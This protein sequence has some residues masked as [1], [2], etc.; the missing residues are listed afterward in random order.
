MAF[1]KLV[2]SAQLDSDLTSVANAIRA[3]SGTSGQLAFPAGFVSE[4]NAISGGGG[5]TGKYTGTFTLVNDGFMPEITHNL[6]TDKIAVMIFPQANSTVTPHAGYIAWSVFFIALEVL[7]NGRSIT[8]DY[9]AYNSDKFPSALT[10]TVGTDVGFRYANGNSS[11]WTSQISWDVGNISFTDRGH[12]LTA[13]S[14][15]MTQQ[16]MAA[17]SYDVVIWKLED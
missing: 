15:K 1:D 8:L 10:K 14:Y 2:D 6:G 13:N 12:T 3:K 7:L 5:G 17:G 9:T 11:P 16:K 4:I